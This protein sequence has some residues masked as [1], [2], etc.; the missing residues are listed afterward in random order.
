[1]T[2]DDGTKITQIQILNLNL[3]KLKEK[4]TGGEKNILTLSPAQILFEIFYSLLVI[5]FFSSFPRNFYQ[6]IFFSKCTLKLGRCGLY[7]LGY[8]H[9]IH[10]FIRVEVLSGFC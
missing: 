10:S 8:L 5:F 6:L 3:H 2:I 9:C 7:L 1:M 4:Y